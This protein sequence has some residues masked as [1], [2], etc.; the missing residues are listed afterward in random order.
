MISTKNI[1]LTDPFAL[2]VIV[3]THVLTFGGLIG[4]FIKDVSSFQDRLPFIFGLAIVYLVFTFLLY[5]RVRYIKWMLS[6]PCQK[7]AI[8][9]KND[10]RYIIKGVVGAVCYSFEHS[11]KTHTTYASFFIRQ[12][13]RELLTRSETVT[14]HFYPKLRFSIIKEAYE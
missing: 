3:V 7:Q 2:L 8:L 12:R 11:G 14:V 10:R 9:Q 1:L 6:Y 13:F 4:I 5:L